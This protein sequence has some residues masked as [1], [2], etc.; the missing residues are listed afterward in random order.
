[1]RQPHA[2]EHLFRSIFV[3]R[4]VKLE[5]FEE[6]SVGLLVEHRLEVLRGD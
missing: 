4:V 3:N 6:E 1:M 5:R 2:L